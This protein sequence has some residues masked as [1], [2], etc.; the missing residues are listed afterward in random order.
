MLRAFDGFTGTFPVL[1][2]LRLAPLLFVR[3][4]ELRQAEWSQFDLD[5]GE[6]RYLVTKT[7]TDHLVPLSTQS[8]AILRDLHALTGAG[9]Y[10]SLARAIETDR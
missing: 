9:R 2:A 10:V 1:C 5:K 7:D 4:G 8:I 6:W 3:P